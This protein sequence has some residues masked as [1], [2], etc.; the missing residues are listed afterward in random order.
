MA[1]TPPK[2][3]VEKREQTRRDLISATLDSIATKGFA[4]TTLEKVSK[5]AGVSRG[6]VN[7]HFESKEKLLIEALN[8]MSEE[9]AASW[10]RALARADPDPLSQLVAMIDSDFHPRACTRKKVAVW[11][12]FLGEA[13]SRQAYTV[14]C[15][16]RHDRFSEAMEEC[17]KDVA[18]LGN[19]SNID[20]KIVAR[21][22]G[23]LIDSLWRDLM[24]SPRNFSREDSKRSCFK[25]LANVF[26]RH[27][28]EAGALQPRKR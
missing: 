23:A 11:Y 9:Y 19:Y 20:Y 21:G 27:F 7:F 8:Q 16:R 25:Y 2:T 24:L 18:E 17:C 3:R 4:E 22:L 12:G 28:D 1:R 6:L 14:V 15:Q 13:R 26:P 10:T 5:R